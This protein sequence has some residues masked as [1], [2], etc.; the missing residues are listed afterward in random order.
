[1]TTSTQPRWSAE[2]PGWAS[3]TTSTS[4]HLSRGILPVACRGSL[5]LP[6]GMSSPI[7][8]R[9]LAHQGVGQFRVLGSRRRRRGIVSG[10]CGRLGN[11]LASQTGSVGDDY[12]I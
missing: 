6:C 4:S 1:M 12:G 5:P 7:S 2:Q 8:A 11:E 9:P 10:V 3:L